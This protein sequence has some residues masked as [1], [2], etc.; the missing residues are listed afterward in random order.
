VRGVFDAAGMAAQFPHHAGHGLGI[1]HPEPPYI[2]REATET[3][4]AG[5]VVTLE[6]GLYVDGIG[7]IRIE[8]NYL[9]TEAGF[10][11]LSRHEITLH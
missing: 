7:G 1:A 9:I 11:C 4:V 3:L 5:D 10:E 6:P 8:R 2:V